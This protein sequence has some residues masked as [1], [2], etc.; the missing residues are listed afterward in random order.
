MVR[1][2]KCNVI[3]SFHHRT[4]APSCFQHHAISFRWCDG[5]MVKTGWY[6]GKIFI[7][8]QS[9]S[10]HCTIAFS[11]SYHRVYGRNKKLRLYKRRIVRNCIY[12]AFFYLKMFFKVFNVY[13]WK[14]LLTFILTIH[15]ETLFDY[16][17]QIWWSCLSIFAI[18]AIKFNTLIHINK[19]T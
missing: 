2:W 19:L 9:C 6:D 3:F 15:I 4:I 18:C 12:I 10:H 5:T 8:V 7:I 17:L 13:K 14:M 11:Q 1:W 16:S